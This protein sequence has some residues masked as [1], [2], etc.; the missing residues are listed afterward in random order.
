M[1]VLKIALAVLKC[2]EPTMLSYQDDYDMIIWTIKT[3]C[4]VIEND[5]GKELFTNISK[6]RIDENWVLATI[7]G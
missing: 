6:M 7:I 3:P 2:L 4:D 1:H 5:E